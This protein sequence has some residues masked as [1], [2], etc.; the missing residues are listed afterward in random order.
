MNLNA[1]FGVKL[2]PRKSRIGFH[3]G[4]AFITRSQILRIIEMF[5]MVQEIFF[6]ISKWKIDII[7]FVIA[8][9]TKP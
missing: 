1:L 6:D 8:I 3:Y 2:F 5:K 7:K 4:T 9:F